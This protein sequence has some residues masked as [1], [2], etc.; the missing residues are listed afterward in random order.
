MSGESMVKRLSCVIA[1]IVILLSAM[2]I[3]NLV[4][5]EVQ[6]LSKA[7]RKEITLGDQ[8]KVDVRPLNF[9][10]RAS[11]QA[12]TVKITYPK[13]GA[14]FYRRSV[15]V[16]GYAIASSSD[17]KLVHLEYIWKW[18][19][20]E[21]RGSREISPPMESIEFMIEIEDLWLGANTIIVIVR[22]E[23][24]RDGL[25]LITIY[26]KDI[27]PPTVEITYPKNNVIFHFP[28]ITVKGIAR[29]Y[30]ATYGR[31]I[32]IAKL[33]WFHSW[34]GGA[35]QG[36]LSFD[37]LWIEIPFHISITLRSGEN[38]ISIVAEDLAGN[39]GNDS[40]K[41]YY[42]GVTADANGPYYGKVGEEIQFYGD[43]YGGTPP[44]SWHWD[45]GDG[46][47]SN[48]RNPKHAYWKEGTYTV[49]LTVTDGKGIS[50]TDTTK[51]IVDSTP[52]TIQITRPVDA[53][54]INDKEIFYLPGRTIIFG[55]IT[56]EVNA[57]D[58]IGIAKVDF[59][60]DARKLCTDNE[61]PYNC[62]F[63]K[64][65]IGKHT[66]KAV[67]HDFSGNTAADEKEVW[68]VNL[69]TSDENTLRKA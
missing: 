4:D 29:D 46:A 52:P 28:D 10:C 35:E 1:C 22:D 18:E 58:N 36:T 42:M 13:D 47:S 64:F 54:Y 62:L 39:K 9:S 63:D 53:L 68:I 21:C 34:E 5:T 55:P 30:N 23:C 19:C 61:T 49:T 65:I 48:E 14:V 50:S 56:I 11:S 31:G 27:S 15:V 2:P 44:Y 38:L 51:A 40:V 45:F 12:P 3:L 24:G 33:H 41:V 20:G 17:C 43:A 7:Q 8:M 26:Y 37:M 59:Y 32:G 60:I 25:D 69:S 6:G 67:A 16:T 57:S 66:I